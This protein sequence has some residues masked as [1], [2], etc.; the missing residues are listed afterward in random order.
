MGL[1]QRDDSW[2]LDKIFGAWLAK[3]SGGMYA[4]RVEG[5]TKE[6][7]Q[8]MVPPLTG[9]LETHHQQINDDEQYELIA[10][11]ALEAIDDADLQDRK[12]KHDILNPEFLGSFWK[13]NLDRKYVFTAEK[14][15]LEN[16]VDHGVPWAHAADEIYKN[17]NRYQNPY[18][19]WI[20]AQMKG[21]LF[22]MLAPAWNWHGSSSD[23]PDA[24]LEKLRL[25]LELSAQDGWIAHR[26]IGIAGEL[27]VSAMV[28][29]GIDHDPM[30]HEVTVQYPAAVQY[31]SQI[32]PDRPAKAEKTI[33]H[34]VTTETLLAD[35]QRVKAAMLLFDDSKVSRV[36][37][38]T[39]FE[40]IDAA[41]AVYAETP[42]P[43]LWD[44]A[45]NTAEARAARYRQE[46]IAD[47]RTRLGEN[48]AWL[49][50]RLAL[51]KHDRHFGVHTIPNNAAIAVGLIYGDGDMFQTYQRATECG[52]DTDCNA[53]N[54]A[55]ILGAYLGYK[56]IPNYEKR[57]VRGEILSPLTNWKEMS[58]ET[59]AKRTLAQAQR[60]HLLF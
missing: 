13:D 31:H 47:A 44:K 20:G 8:K 36:D 28:A 5:R 29:V 9:W 6:A 53:G 34:G 42:D 57:F 50:Q 2:Y 24:D 35:M 19:D 15:A 11:M 49:K 38:T 32:L 4:S 3:I 55:A 45:W 48:K 39:F 18:F 51:L 52:L 21:E 56:L 41:I 46:L 23:S 60:L 26:G 59:L 16:A 43:R 17:D 10:L 40:C 30:N 14:A 1:N 33:I 22:G 7:I 37:I 27:F 54:A 25:C 12:A 58:I